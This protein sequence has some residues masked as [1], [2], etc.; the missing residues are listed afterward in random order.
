MIGH[1]MVHDGGG[2]PVEVERRWE[3]RPGAV[4]GRMQCSRAREEGEREVEDG[5]TPGAGLAER[6]RRGWNWADLGREI[7]AKKREGEEG[8]TDWAERERELGRAS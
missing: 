2:A 6:G 1:L 5:L 8:A 7:D 3:V 4:G